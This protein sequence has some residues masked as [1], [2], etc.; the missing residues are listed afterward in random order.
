MDHVEE[1]VD[2]RHKGWCVHCGS[3]IDGA[4]S[5]RDHVPSKGLLKEPHSPNLP[6]IL[7]CKA[8]NEGFS[9]DEEYF[10]AFLG[11]VL[12]GTTDPERQQDPRVQRTLSR[13]PALRSR[14]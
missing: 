1:F 12:S 3:G 7:V 5:N 6:F 4:V 11:C 2:E 14:I 9:L 10:V 13:S 8:C